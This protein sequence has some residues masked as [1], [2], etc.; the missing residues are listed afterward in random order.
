MYIS[1]TEQNMEKKLLVFKL[2]AFELVA[3]ISLYYD[4]NTCH[5]QLMCSQTDPIF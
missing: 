3:G 5:C 1:T 2:I 4:E